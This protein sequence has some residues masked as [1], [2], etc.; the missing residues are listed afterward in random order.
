MKNL[1]CF[2]LLLVP[3]FSQAQ[4]IQYGSFKIMDAE[5]VYQKVFNQDSITVEKLVQFLKSL[6]TIANVQ[7]GDGTVTAE[8]TYLTVDF[9][10][11]KVPQTSVPAIIQ[12]GKFNGKLSFDVKAGKYRATL[13][14][15]QMKG[16]TGKKKIVDPENLTD[17]A[18][19]D[20]G[21]AL[22][23]VWCDPNMLGLLEQQITDRLKYKDTNTDWK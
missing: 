23:K 7:A 15:I 4:T 13:R 18:C 22:S 17:Y 12:T 16:D 2:L 21:T 1:F 3:C 5:V 20:N 9:K 6:P 8:L 14:G 10:K 11:F 19:T